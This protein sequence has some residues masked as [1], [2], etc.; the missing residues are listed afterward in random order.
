MKN[1]LILL[2]LFSFFLPQAWSKTNSERLNEI[3]K[4][5]RLAFGSCNKHWRTQPM[6]NEISRKTPDL[7][8][9][10]G[11]NIYADDQGIAEIQEA[12]L[13]QNKVEAYKNFKAITPIIGTWDDHD[14]G[15]NN[16]GYEYPFK[17]LS[18]KYAL[19]FFEEPLESP[20]RSQEGI[21]T[22]YTFGQSGQKVKIILLDNRYFK[23]IKAGALLGEAQWAWLEQELKKSDASL[24]LIV[25][26]I[27]ILTSKT[28]HSEEW[29]DYPLEKKRLR[30]LMKASN[31]PYLYLAGDRHFSAIFSKGDEM[32]FLSSGMTHVAGKVVR[33][34]IRATYPSPVFI[35]NFGMI[36][37]SWDNSTPV[38]DLSIGVKNGKSIN[39]TKI[40][41]NKN[42]WMRI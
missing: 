3:N 30:E 28:V 35:L 24:H 12:Y 41:W 2:F 29:A 19:D 26:G 10:T 21:F 6:W 15:V 23:D 8:L 33:P 32:E 7:F 39:S 17:K 18:Q 38:L 14:Y 31:K 37:F 9:W 36:D 1:Q 40:K 27:S 11:D 5:E 4:I 42:Q 13:F 22:S 34:L 20:R 16:G 25:S